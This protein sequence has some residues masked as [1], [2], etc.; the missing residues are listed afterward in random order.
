M[1]DDVR[2]GVNY[3][4]ARDWL[5]SWLDWNPDDIAAD[6]AAIRALGCDHI[7][8]H[9][10]WPIFQPNPNL[11]S[12]SALARLAELVDIAT[13]LDLD[14]HLSVLN[15]WMSGTYF[16]PFWQEPSMGVY[17][18]P[19]V[20]G[21]QVRLIE[22]IAE[23]GYGRTRLVGIDIGNEPNAL[24]SFPGN[25]ATRQQGDAWLTRL[26]AACDDALP[27]RFHVVGVDHVPWLEDTSVFS[28]DVLGRVGSASIVHSWVYFTGALERYGV[29]GVG[30]HHLARYLVEL[31]RAFGETRERPVWLQEI[32][33]SPGWLR[34]AD[35]AEFAGS[36]VTEALKANPWAMTWWGSHDIDR[37]LAG[38]DELEYDL[39]LLTVENEVKPVGLA[40][41]DAIARERNRDGEPQPGA[42][43]ERVE[44]TLPDDRVPDL[45]FAD[46]FFALVATGAHPVIVRESRAEDLIDRV[47]LA[48]SAAQGGGR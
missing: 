30:T 9:C 43:G 17:S 45:S 13:D 44:L 40:V 22:A 41:A 8:A 32:G 3:I 25:G 31:A 18:D 6:L 11:I 38:F 33:V 12:R 14:V 16:R 20:I 24:A 28:R 27:G 36:I 23:I 10:L 48:D 26:L 2:F 21:A 37:R 42:V 1:T 19:D 7:R 5:Y 46:E 34:G 29:E 4:P 35:V 39:G 47:R 15:G